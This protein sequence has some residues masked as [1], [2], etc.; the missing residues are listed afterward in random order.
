MHL[1]KTRIP[2][3]PAAVEFKPACVGSRDLLDALAA[4]LNRQPAIA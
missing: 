2:V 1:D 3:S 4:E